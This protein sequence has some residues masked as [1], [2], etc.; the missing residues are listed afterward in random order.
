[1]PHISVGLLLNDVHNMML[2]D[3]RMIGSDVGW[4]AIVSLVL[5][6]ADARYGSS[7]S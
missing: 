2:C 3:D 4:D 6:R 5:V 7:H 1:M